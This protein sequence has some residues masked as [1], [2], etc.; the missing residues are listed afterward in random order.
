[1][2]ETLRTGLRDDEHVPPAMGHQPE[3]GMRDQARSYE[4]KVAFVT[5]A[6][7]GIG[8]ATALAFA[9]E[10]ANVGSLTFRKSVTRR[11]PYH[12]GARRASASCKV[13]RDFE[14]RT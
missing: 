9:R 5:G 7:N 12:R 13:R 4:G 8:R 3:V 2:T 6:A 11:Q 14:P 10:G 1:M